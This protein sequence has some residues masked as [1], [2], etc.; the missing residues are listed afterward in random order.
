[1]YTLLEYQMEEVKPDS[2]VDSLV[3]MQVQMAAQDSLQHQ[4]IETDIKKTTIIQKYIH[5][6]Q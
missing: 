4:L 5:N 6:T 3:N 2:E 1:M